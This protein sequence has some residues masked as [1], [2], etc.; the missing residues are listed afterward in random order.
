MTRVKRMVQNLDRAKVSKA[1]REMVLM[2]GCS[3][4][5]RRGFGVVSQPFYAK[6]I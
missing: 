3:L 4:N 6:F 5:G 1:H 2:N